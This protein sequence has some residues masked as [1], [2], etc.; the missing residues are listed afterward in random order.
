LRAP[1]VVEYGGGM[2]VEEYWAKV[3]EL[4]L[5]PS[6]SDYDG[7]DWW[8]ERARRFYIPDP[9]L[10]SPDERAAFIGDLGNQVRS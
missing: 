3:R 2:T 6:E 8:D 4:G 10:L 7:N 5:K 9:T 1:G